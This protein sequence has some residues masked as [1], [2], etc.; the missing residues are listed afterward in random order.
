MDEIILSQQSIYEGRVVKLSVAEVQLPNGTTAKREIITHPGAVALVALDEN[1]DVLLVRQYRSAAGKQLLEIPA[2]TLEPGEEPLVCAE[3]ELQ[4][5]TGYHP[6]KLQS[7][8][9]IYTAPGYTSEFIHLYL[10]TDLT[11]SR[12]EQDDDE[13]IAVERASLSEAIAM[14]ER[15]DICDGKSVSALLRTALLIGG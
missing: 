13:F 4:E 15:G 1:G 14:I 8:G 3:R 7:L 12:L 2:G 5:E 9:G 6:G 11:E 10:A